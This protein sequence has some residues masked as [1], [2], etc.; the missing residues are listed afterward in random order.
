[1]TLNLVEPEDPVQKAFEDL[2]GRF[3]L[4]LQ[5]I[6]VGDN[7]TRGMIILDKSTYES[8]IQNL[9]AIFR[10]EGNRWGNQLR[11]ICETPLF[12]ESRPSRNIQLADHIAYSV[13]RRYNANDLSYFNCIESRFDRDGGV[14]HGLSHLQRTAKFCTCP[15]C[16][17]RNNP[18]PPR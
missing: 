18:V 2:S 15:A 12:V 10:A 3:D 6:S 7:K 9:A 4:Y 8:N 13:F 11:N 14:V 17:T 5:R 16:I 1:M